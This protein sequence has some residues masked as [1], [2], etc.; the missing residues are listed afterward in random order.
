MSRGSI[1][2]NAYNT[3]VLFLYLF[4]TIYES[5][6]PDSSNIIGATNKINCRG[7]A[8]FNYFLVFGLWRRFLTPSPSTIEIVIWVIILLADIFLADRR[9][10]SGGHEM[11]FD[12]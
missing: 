7:I 2:I 11:L 1:K 6:F 5:F 12:T 9:I 10:E 3:Q 8:I 4:L